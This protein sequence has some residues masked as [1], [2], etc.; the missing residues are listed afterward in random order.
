VTLCQLLFFADYVFPRNRWLL[1]LAGGIAFSF[2]HIIFFS[3]ISLVF[4][5]IAGFYLAWV[6]S[7]TE[8]VLFTAIL[9]GILGDLV[10]TLGLGQ[11]FWVD[12]MGWL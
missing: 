10:F 3:V 12:M 8:S 2:V 5:F 11:H 6:Y 4:T 1:I 7:R 9:H